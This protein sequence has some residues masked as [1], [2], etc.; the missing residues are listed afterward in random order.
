MNLAIGTGKAVPEVKKKKIPP[1]GCL[2]N[3]TSFP[4]PTSIYKKVNVMWFFFYPLT[5][6][7]G[8]YCS[9]ITITHLFGN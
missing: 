9:E 7:D 5:K 8:D 4:P 6:M 1:L 2:F 3:T